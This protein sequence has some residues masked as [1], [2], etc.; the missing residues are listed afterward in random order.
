MTDM[1]AYERLIKTFTPRD[2]LSS[3]DIALLRSMPL[4]IATYG[5][6]EEIIAQDSEVSESCLM[7]TGWTGRAVYLESGKRQITALHI[8]GDFV[9]LHG[10]T[11]KYMDHSVVA[12]TATQVAFVRHDELKKITHVSPHL[13][14]L[15]WMLTTIDGAVQRTTIASL[16]RRPA[17][18]RLGHLLCELDCRL[19]VVGLAQDHRYDVPLVQEELADILGLSV[20]HMNRTIQ[21]LR[22][23]GLVT[24]QGSRIVIHDFG[25]LTQFSGFDPRY[26][27]FIKR[28][29]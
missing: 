1:D 18:E 6:G 21:D 29:R 12:L 27:N 20:V 17:L 10:F 11:L 14:R 8:A 7:M 22:K 15:F 28:E 16:G 19:S 25:K 13:T 9:D 24:W 4:R 3:D 2:D 5:K 23:A 26:L